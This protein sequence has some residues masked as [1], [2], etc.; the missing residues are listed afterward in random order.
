MG[1][2]G[3]KLL[4]LGYD[5]KSHHPKADLLSVSLL[6]QQAL[7]TLHASA[8]C[9][10]RLCTNDKTPKIDRASFVS[11][12]KCQ[13]L[14]QRA[15]SALHASKIWSDWLCQHDT[16]PRFHPASFVCVP[17]FLSIF[18]DEEMHTTGNVFSF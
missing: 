13:K 14:V 5:W 9:S 17:S 16:P 3:F 11:S 2:S 1:F 4:F 15:L 18:F 8:F 6:S 7:V 12:T 10:G